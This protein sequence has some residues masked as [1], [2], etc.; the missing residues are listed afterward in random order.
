MAGSVFGVVR[1]I[2]GNGTKE[3]VVPCPRWPSR[4]RPSRPS[5]PS[6]GS[7][8][9]PV[10]IGPR[11]E[12]FTIEQGGGRWFLVDA[13]QH[14]E[15]GLE[16]TLGPYDTLDLAKAAAGEQREA[17]PE[18]S[19]L[20]DRL[21]DAASRPRLKVMRGGRKADAGSATDEARGRESTRSTRL[22]SPLPRRRRRRRPGSIDSRRADARRAR[23]QI[24]A[25]ESL[26]VDKAEQIVRRDLDGNTPAVATTVLARAL[27]R[28]ALSA[29]R[30]PRDRPGRRATG[31]GRR[32]ARRRRRLRPARRR[33]R[34]RSGAGG[35]ERARARPRC[36]RAGCPAGA[37]SRA[38][39]KAPAGAA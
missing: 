24:E 35:A 11:T 15:L 25:L 7:A 20:R 22:T 39:A 27:R 9:R 17:P 21:A 18:A 2:G 32:V 28:A 13:E 6:R 26:G 12:R 38:T 1:D 31:A 4:E 14:D 5:R 34:A 19:P 8:T 23:T 37:S 29:A 16:R 10:A 3:A 30:G 36:A 33:G